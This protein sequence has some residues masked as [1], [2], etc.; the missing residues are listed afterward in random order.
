MHIKVLK[1][2]HQARWEKLFRQYAEF[3]QTSLPPEAVAHVWQW[4]LNPSHPL[5][6]LMAFHNRS[7]VGIIHYRPYPKSLT[8]QQA[9]FVDDIFVTPRAR[10][11]GVATTL[12]QTLEKI[13][14]AQGWDSLRWITAEDNYPARKL[15]DCVA[16]K[17]HWRVYEKPIDT[18]FD[19]PS[20]H[21]VSPAKAAPPVKK[22][23]AATKTPRT[24]AAPSTQDS[25]SPK[26][27]RATATVGRAASTSTTA[28]IS[29]TAAISKAASTPK[30]T[31]K[32]STK[33]LPA[34]V[35]VQ[36]TNKTK[37]SS[38]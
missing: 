19:Q 16:Q 22:P 11:K 6:G 18:N 17:T 24:Q 1:Q 8:G 21:T 20:F 14:A 30:T 23:K 28:P 10:S 34:A 7:A 27:A 37:T 29:P 15:Y 35:P 12:L 13:A 33:K 4:L 5:C 26:T 38:A 31:T 36:P 32:A 9:C 3:Y 2:S 25:A